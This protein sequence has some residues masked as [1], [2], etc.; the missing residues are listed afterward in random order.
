[1]AHRGKTVACNRVDRSR[2]GLQPEAA[3]GIERSPKNR[4]LLKWLL[5]EMLKRALRARFGLGDGLL[6]AG[7]RR[8]LVETADVR[9][10]IARHVDRA[11]HGA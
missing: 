10:D 11:A 7:L 5:T 3:A 6:P 4:G 2:D 8:F 9:L 1:M